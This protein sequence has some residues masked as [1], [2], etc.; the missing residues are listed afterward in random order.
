MHKRTLTTALALTTLF[1]ASQS[2]QPT[3]A[4]QSPTARLIEEVVAGTGQ[5]VAHP[6][7]SR[8][9][10]PAKPVSQPVAQRKVVAQAPLA[11]PALGPRFI[12]KPYLRKVKYGKHRWVMV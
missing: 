10:A 4:R 7:A 8:K 3:T 11:F 2:T 1:T 6:V 5:A 9:P 12:E